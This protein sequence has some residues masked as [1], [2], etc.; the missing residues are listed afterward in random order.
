MSN[1]KHQT[2]G[3]SSSRFYPHSSYI[4]QRH[5]EKRLWE[6]ASNWFHDKIL[7]RAIR[8][9]NVLEILRNTNSACRKKTGH[10][11]N[12]KRLKDQKS[13]RENKARRTTP[14]GDKGKTQTKKISAKNDDKSSLI[15]AV[16]LFV[17]DRD[18]KKE[19][20]RDR[21]RERERERE[22]ERQR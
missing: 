19:R 22:S 4:S 17:R 12:T 20:E 2:E 14:L 6:H 16:L 15:A 18:R 11:H 8:G 9:Q 5:S 7:S 10:C 21:E 13:K 1:W 3:L